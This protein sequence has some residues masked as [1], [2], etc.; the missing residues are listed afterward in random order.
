LLEWIFVNW[1]EEHISLE[2][3]RRTNICTLKGKSTNKVIYEICN[4]LEYQGYL[5]WTG[6]QM[7]EINGHLAQYAWKILNKNDA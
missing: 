7:V 4:I 1:R 6:Y 2:D 3:I 5:K